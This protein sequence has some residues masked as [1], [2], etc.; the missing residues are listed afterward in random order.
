MDTNIIPRISVI[1][2][3]YNGEK[4]IKRAIDSIIRQ[5]FADFELIIIN[6][7]SIDRSM[8]IVK[9][10]GDRRI[11]TVENEQNTGLSA[12]RNQGLSTARGDLIA[13]LDCDDISHP[14]RL[15]LEVAFL[16]THPDFGL[17]GSYTRLIDMNS[18]PTGVLWREHIP[19]EKFPLRV[20][21]GNTFTTSS[22]MLRKT[23]LPP[24]RFR[25]GFAPAEDYE[26]WTRMLKKWKGW[27]I[28]KILTDYRIHPAGTSIEKKALQ[29][30]AIDK[31]IA[32]EIRELGIEPSSEELALH[33]KN[34]GFA[35]TKEETE[36]F[37][38]QRE[39]WLR[40]LIEQNQKVGR[41]P[42]ELFEEVVA[43]KWL[44]NC[45][46]NARLGLRL[47]QIFRHSP[48]SQKMNW[49]KNWKKLIRL[50]IKCTLSKD[51]I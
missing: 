6:D 34:Y 33:R 2:P 37:L 13:F 18:K 29:Q 16:D 12:V 38:G 36:K 45:D 51:K 17:V 20:M 24:T 32:S 31:I 26:L 28:P 1:M 40:K 30:S 3:V 21:F 23:A 35:G 8:E 11:V 41:Y 50:G 44:E 39:M 14:D 9:S 5:T 48:I 25:D 42:N 46:A 27:N 15:E 49:R 47:W 4:Y 22:V 19:C 10:F 43:E 7:G